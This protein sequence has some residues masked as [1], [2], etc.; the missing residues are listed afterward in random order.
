MK[1][2]NLLFDRTR[3]PD[4]KQKE[5]AKSEPKHDVIL[6]DDLFLCQLTAITEATR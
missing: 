2:S 6:H 1:S 4:V 5:T 3:R